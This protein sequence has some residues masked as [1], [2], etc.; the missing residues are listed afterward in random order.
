MSSKIAL[1]LAFSLVAGCSTSTFPLADRAAQEGLERSV[2]RTAAFEHSIYRKGGDEAYQVVFIEGDG[3]PW[4]RAGSDPSADPTPRDALAFDLMLATP[5]HA[6]Y[7]TRPCY[8]DTWKESCSPNVW[9]SGRFSADVVS[10]LA[11]A[12]R[13]ATDPQRPVIVVGYSGGG[14]LAV[15]VAAE[16]DRVDGV[17]T[18]SGLLDSDRWT[19][20]HG[21]ERLGESINPASAST[22]ATRVHLHGALDAVVPIELARDAFFSGEDAELRVFD[23]Y[24]HVCCWRR[25]W[26]R[27]WQDVETA[28]GLGNK[29]R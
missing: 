1:L 18:V 8:F 5:A 15:L 20:H 10:S 7:V 27:I 16:L 25:D 28:L 21:Y 29:E 13:T 2:V 12:I 9:T 11:S 22:G 19:D 24:G 4:N 23:D 17:V 14:A 6:I 26:P 3:R